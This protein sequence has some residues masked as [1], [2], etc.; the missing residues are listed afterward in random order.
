MAGIEISIVMPVRN[1]AAG[2]DE[3]LDSVLAQELD[4]PARFVVVEELGGRGQR[5][6]PGEKQRPQTESLQAHQYSPP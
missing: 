3:A 4:A 6:G 2:I 1:E 5:D